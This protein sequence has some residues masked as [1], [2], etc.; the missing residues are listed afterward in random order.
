MWQHCCLGSNC[1]SDCVKMTPD[2]N[3]SKTLVELKE[4]LLRQEKLLTN[5]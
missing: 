5:K 3:K 1:D 2:E 4:I